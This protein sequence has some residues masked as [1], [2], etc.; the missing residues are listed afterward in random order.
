MRGLKPISCAVGG[1]LQSVDR[2]GDDKIQAKLS[3]GKKTCRDSEPIFPGRRFRRDPLNENPNPTAAAN[4]RY[5]RGG[6]E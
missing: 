5:T 3:E 2:A 4:R 6:G 1:V